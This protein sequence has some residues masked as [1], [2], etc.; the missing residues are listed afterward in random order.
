VNIPDREQ[1]L[2]RA[3]CSL[4]G[5]AIGDAFGEMFFSNPQNARNCVERDI[6]PPGPWWHTDDTEMAVAIVS[7]LERFGEIDQDALARESASRFQTD[8]LRGY[9]SM[10]ALILQR[11][12]KGEDWRSV[13]PAVF[14]GKGSMGNGAAMRV[15]PLGAYFTEDLDAVVT[16]AGK[17]AMVTHAH[18]EGQAG[19][20]AVAVAAATAW[21]FRDRPKGETAVEML[22]EAYDRTPESETR[23]GIRKAA[24]ELPWEASSRDAAQLLG[25]G[26]R[27]TAPD[28]VPYVLW[29]AAHHID[30][31]VEAL[32]QTVSNGGDCD[33]NC[34]I[35][36]GI[37][38]L[39]CGERSIP[40]RWRQARE[41][42]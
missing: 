40:D 13:S 3:H 26:T 37:V 12:A 17:T 38:A 10:A 19:A 22:K 9:G 6:L 29:C 21:R 41:P 36:G 16:Q 25:R 15:A 39:Y 34:A 42:Y 4:E 33:T 24:V 2:K 27:V 1:C 14:G 11:L 30:N 7:V 20:I 32:I 18:P 23:R 35:V 8:P 5:L 28:T 31:Y